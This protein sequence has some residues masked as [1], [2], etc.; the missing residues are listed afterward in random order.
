[1]WSAIRPATARGGLRASVSAAANARML[2]TARG[3]AVTAGSSA[4]VSRAHGPAQPG[5]RGVVTFRQLQPA[6]GF[7]AAAAAA[8]AEKP[9]RA[10]TTRKPKA[11]KAAGA[12][13]K[14]KKSTKKAAAKKATAKK[15]AARKAQTPEEK[16]KVQV[17]KL[18]K[19]ALLKEPSKLPEHPWILFVA[20]QTKGTKTEGST[21]TTIMADLSRSFKS[22]SQLELQRLRDT[23]KKNGESNRIAYKAWVESHPV[24]TI[25]EANRARLHLNRLAG[26]KHRTIPD[27]RQPKRAQGVFAIFTKARW[28]SG[29]FAGRPVTE[30][31]KEMAAEWKSLSPP[32]RQLYDARAKAEAQRYENEV[33]SVFGRPV[34]RSPSASP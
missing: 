29:M 24:G 10:A 20:E 30:A 28:D 16:K 6:R 5:W 26:S 22:L 32:E 23:A 31:S 25:A 8:A 18:K 14:K 9:Q 17:S 13:K 15:R 34:K 33:E 7:A 2:T 3:F 12:P 27:E 21:I 1:M 4:I 19:T 11:T